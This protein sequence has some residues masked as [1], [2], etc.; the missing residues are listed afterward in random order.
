VRRRVA[1]QSSSKKLR[2]LATVT[3]NFVVY[4]KHDGQVVTALEK[5]QVALFLD[6]VG[7][8]FPSVK[9]SDLPGIV[10]KISNLVRNQ[11]SLTFSTGLNDG[12]AHKIE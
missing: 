7:A 4:R 5:N 6:G 9:K 10:E 8:F 11:F 2:R 12:K 1:F 3:V